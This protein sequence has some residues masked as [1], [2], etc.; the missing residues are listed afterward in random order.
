MQPAAI[1]CKA[2]TQWQG[3]TGHWILHQQYCHVVHQ[4]SSASRYLHPAEI[5]AGSGRRPLSPEDTAGTGCFSGRFGQTCA[6]PLYFG[7]RIH[8]ARCQQKTCS[9]L[10]AEIK[11]PCRPPRVS[12]RLRLEYAL[13][14][15]MIHRASYDWSLA[16]T[17][18]P[19]NDAR[20]F[21]H[22]ARKY[23]GFRV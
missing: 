2:S 16:F 15:I 6:F 20:A 21:R 9:G 12:E 19:G 8:F 22:Q 17:S 11:R 3:R 14:R 23:L 5:P 18:K 7:S 10:T 1:K 4:S 13:M